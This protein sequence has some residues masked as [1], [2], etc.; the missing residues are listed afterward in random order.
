ML[1]SQAVD[2]ILT[3]GNRSEKEAIDDGTLAVEIEGG[4]CRCSRGVAHVNVLEVESNSGFVWIHISTSFQA[5]QFLIIIDIHSCFQ[6]LHGD[7]VTSCY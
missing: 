3:I 4:L 6:L 7:G 2:K 1:R 5:H